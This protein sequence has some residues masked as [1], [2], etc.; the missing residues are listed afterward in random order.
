MAKRFTVV[1]VGE[2]ELFYKGYKMPEE[3]HNSNAFINALLEYSV[4]DLVDISVRHF[5]F[6]DYP[7]PVE[8]ITDD[9]LSDLIEVFDEVVDDGYIWLEEEAEFQLY[10]L[11]EEEIIET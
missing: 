7:T 6:T 10:G 4:L 8:D 11:K 9:E 1:Q 2:Y 3:L 5:M